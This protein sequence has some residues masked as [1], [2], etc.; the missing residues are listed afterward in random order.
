MAKYQARKLKGSWKDGYALDVHTTSSVMIGH[1]E[2][3]HPQFDTTYSEVGALM[4]RLKYRG[5]KTTLADLVDTAASFIRDW[6]LDI[7]A[8]VPV[9]PTK[10]YRTFQPV[11]ALSTELA[12]VLKVPILKSAVRKTKQIPELKNIYDAEE[13]KRLLAGA[14]E[15][16]EQALKGQKILLVDD[17]YR[18]GATMNAITEVLLTAG[19]SE[20]N[21]FAFTQTRTKR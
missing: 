6:K 3:G 4:N 16:N 1:N 12:S 11:L 2:Y 13:R 10:V 21:V 19:A 5:D 20:V 8:I 14:F 18:S 9:P 15:A 17:L 7:T